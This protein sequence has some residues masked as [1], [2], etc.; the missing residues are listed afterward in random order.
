MQTIRKRSC[1]FSNLCLRSLVHFWFPGQPSLHQTSFPNAPYI[2]HQ[3][4]CSTPAWPHRHIPGLLT[5]R[6]DQRWSQVIILV[7]L[8]WPYETWSVHDQLCLTLC[9]PWTVGRQAPLFME[10]PRQDYWSGLPFPPLAWRR[11]DNGTY[12]WQSQGLPGKLCPW[13]LP[14]R[15]FTSD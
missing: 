2:S 5:K 9:N 6:G 8:E 13:S 1:H 3:C 15:L 4:F 7:Q 12:Q 14:G 10:F 11:M